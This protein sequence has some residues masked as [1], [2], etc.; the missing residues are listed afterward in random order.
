VR[1]GDVC[2]ALSVFVA[3]SLLHLSVPRF[4]WISI[5]LTGVWLLLAVTIGRLYRGLE[6]QNEKLG[7]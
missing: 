1:I 3:A 5:A 7:A 6:A 2:S 4:A